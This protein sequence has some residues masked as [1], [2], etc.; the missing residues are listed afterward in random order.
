MRGLSSF[1]IDFAVYCRRVSVAMLMGFGGTITSPGMVSM[2]D[3]INNK[4]ALFSCKLYS[5][6]DWRLAGA[7]LASQPTARAL[8]GYSHGGSSLTYVTNMGFLLHVAIGLDP[9]IWLEV[10]P[11]GNT[12]KDTTCFHNDNY[13]Q[14]AG[15]AYYTKGPNWNPKNQTL[16][17][18]ETEDW[19][20]YVD[21]DPKIQA[22]CFNKIFALAN[23]TKMM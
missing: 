10:D 17:T 6:A 11:L 15:H 14:P 19:H 16:T 5:W 9:S 20:L 21:T 3:T 1:R 2:C 18:L 7:W 22:Y 4:S 12:V 23:S 13:W 8:L